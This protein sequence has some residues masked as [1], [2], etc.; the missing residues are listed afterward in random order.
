MTSSTQ[1]HS[2]NREERE[3]L[4]GKLIT[5]EGIDGCGK[6]LQAGRLCESLR[7]EGWQVVHT[8]QPGGTPL[9]QTLRRALLNH[10]AGR[11][12]PIA[13]LLCFLADRLQ[14]HAE[15]IQ[16]ALD[17][18]YVVVCERHHDST[19]AYQG[20]GRRLD[21]KPLEAFVQAWVQLPQLTLWLDVN[22]KTAYERSLGRTQISL[23]LDIPSLEKATSQRARTA[24]TGQRT[25]G[26]GALGVGGPEAMSR[27]HLDAAARDFRYRVREGYTQL[28]QENPKRIVRIS[29]CDV[30]AVA[31]H[32]WKA[33]QSRFRV[34]PSAP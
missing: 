30:E 3:S 15:C 14:H 8:Y 33:L 27:N 9:G 28:Y 11:I 21:L 19:V 20:F 29:D 34:T 26:E 18:G 23:P 31:A 6:S 13:E 17:K 7:K 5:L 12:I 32:I 22:L 1:A 24:S 10:A 25:E 16:P 2:S 4:A